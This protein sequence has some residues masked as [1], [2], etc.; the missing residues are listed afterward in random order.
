MSQAFYAQLAVWSEIAGSLA[1]LAVLVYVWQR[2][3]TPAVIASQERKNAELAET[4]RR[5]D[6]ARAQVGEAERALRAA[7]DDVKQIAARA[8]HDAAAERTRAL[9]EAKADGERLVRNAEGELGRQRAATR[10]ALR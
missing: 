2:F 8:E 3:I 5:R 1:F 10:D 4:E 9:S 7:D 6:S